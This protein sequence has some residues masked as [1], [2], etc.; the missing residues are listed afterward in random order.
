MVIC[1]GAISGL[2][3]GITISSV[4]MLLKNLGYRVSL[5]KIDPYLVNKT[6]F[7]ILLSIFFKNLDAGTMN[8]YEHGEVYV[9]DDGFK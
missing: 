9:L 3:K 4:G 6:P 8:P 5:I 7:P 2:G 1:G